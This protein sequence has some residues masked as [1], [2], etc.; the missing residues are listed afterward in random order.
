MLVDYKT[1]RVPD[2]AQ[3]AVRYRLQLDIYA[4]ALQKAT[5]LGVAEKIIWSFRF[6]RELYV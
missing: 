5:G 1:D 4:E 6:G 3:L 2:L